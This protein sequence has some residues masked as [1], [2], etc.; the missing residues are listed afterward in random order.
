VVVLVIVL[1]PV[2]VGLEPLLDLV[3]LVGLVLARRVRLLRPLLV[4]LRVPR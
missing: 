1:A 4:E 3:G 2:V